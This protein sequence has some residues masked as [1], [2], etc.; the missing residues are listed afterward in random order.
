MENS[1]FNLV[2]AGYFGFGNAGDEALLAGLLSGI[3]KAV[4][5]GPLTGCR[6]RPVVLSAKPE[7]TRKLHG[8][9]AVDRRHP[10]AI[11][12]AL[13]KADA[14]WLAGGGLLQQATS[15]RSIYYY[16]G[17]LALAQAHALPTCLFA[18]GVGPLK[19]SG[20]AVLLRILLPRCCGIWV[21]DDLS[22]R[23]L[24]EV[25]GER[26]RRGPQIQVT[27]DPAFLL[28]PAM[29]G[30]EEEREKAPGE[31]IAAGGSRWV[32]A[33]R[34]WREEQ[35]WSGRL[36]AGLAEAAKTGGAA[37][38]LLAMQPEQD[39]P[40]NRQLAAALQDRGAQVHL[41]P[42]PPDFRR[43]IMHIAGADL[44]I[45]MRLH[46]LIMA[47]GAGVPAVAV[48]YD[49]K[50]DALAKDLA[51]PLVSIGA[52]KAAEGDHLLSAVICR[53]EAEERSGGGTATARK[54]M[55]ARLQKQ[56]AAD[57]VEAL[58]VCGVRKKE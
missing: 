38:Q 11:W 45:A 35:G 48:S 9:A 2:L 58:A 4:A 5:A 14:F 54:E 18:Q 53:A 3:N 31:R 39:L 1:M 7:E 42:P 26:H 32:V 33:C 57:L 36:A 22:R 19:T 41:L 28:P 6:I 13:A 25:F 37:L 20:A 52:L 30:G 55:A 29:E 8:V 27:G 44:V 12:R 24:L 23:V 16:L 50:V 17:L 43:V 40:F 21:R 47:A 46:A 51:I 10:A 49:P 15:R 56:V 34:S